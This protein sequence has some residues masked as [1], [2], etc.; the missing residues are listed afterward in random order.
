MATESVVTPQPPEDDLQQRTIQLADQAR[1]VEVRDQRTYDLAAEIK[2][3]LMTM[4][5]EI[6]EHYAPF[7]EKAMATKRAA[8][9]ARKSIADAQDRDL[10]PILAAEK[11][12]ASRLGLYET[13]QRQLQLEA[14]RQAQQE[15]ERLAAER[16][17]AE[18]EQAEQYGVSPAEV[19][20]LCERPL[21]VVPVIPPPAFERKRNLGVRGT[22]H[23]EVHNLRELARAVADGSQP[24]ALLLGLEQT[25]AGYIS[26]STLNSQARALKQALVIPGVKAVLGF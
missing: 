7:L 1:A 22:W 11:L 10:A 12:L 8:E 13:E 23:A 26:S 24:V 6:T 15:A 17:E 2:S 3:A 20:A 25:E 14:Q 18:I 21:E 19:A 16:R 9:A 5:R 4:R